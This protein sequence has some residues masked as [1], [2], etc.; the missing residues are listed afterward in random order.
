[1]KAFV[2]VPDHTPG[3]FVGFKVHV[4]LG[5]GMHEFELA[6]DNEHKEMREVVREVDILKKKL[7][8]AEQKLKTTS[9][10]LNKRDREF[11]DAEPISKKPVAFSF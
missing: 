5:R 1:M 4:F 9:N 8:E 10:R 3:H 2:K 11:D 6:E 7:K